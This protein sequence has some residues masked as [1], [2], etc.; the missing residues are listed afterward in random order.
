VMCVSECELDPARMKWS[1]SFTL[2][3]SHMQDQYFTVVNSIATDRIWLCSFCNNKTLEV[4][5]EET[6]PC[7]FASENTV[8]IEVSVEGR[9]S[10]LTHPP[11][12]P[13]PL[14]FL[15]VGVQVRMCP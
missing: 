11:P 4:E 6:G 14:N 7:I 8:H 3:R 12:L 5:E 13:R 9:N 2:S 1:G 15:Y 10:L